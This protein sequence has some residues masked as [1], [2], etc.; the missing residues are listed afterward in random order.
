VAYDNP[1]ILRKNAKP[2]FIVSPRQKKYEKQFV[3][4]QV[5]GR[6]SLKEAAELIAKAAKTRTENVLIDLTRD[7]LAKSLAVF[8]PG[9]QA[10]YHPKKVRGDYEEAYWDDLNAWL[11]S[12][13]P[14]IK[15]EFQDPNKPSRTDRTA[16]DKPEVIG[17]TTTIQ[18]SGTGNNAERWKLEAVKLG[19]AYL[20]AWRNQSY[21]PTKQDAALYVEGEFST[22]GIYGDR[23][24]VLDAAY[25]ERHALKG[26][27]GH[28]P[29]FKSK[30]PK[31]PEGMRGKLPKPR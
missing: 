28:P 20:A 1:F 16:T 3:R 23:N 15:F 6:Y 11:V 21:E 24:E 17:D 5:D 12:N 27:T 30:K 22:H 7:V 26:I 10:R 19:K 14:R 31:V 25:I 8:E 9:S 18:E 13:E 29:G 4:Q 2:G